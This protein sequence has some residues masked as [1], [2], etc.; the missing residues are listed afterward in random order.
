MVAQDWKQNASTADIACVFY[1]GSSPFK[2][3]QRLRVPKDHFDAATVALDRRSNHEAEFSL[4]VFY[5]LNYNETAPCKLVKLPRAKAEQENKVATK[6]IETIDW[7]KNC[8]I[9]DK[10]Q[11]LLILQYLVL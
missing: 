5:T 7:Y 3:L 1:S 6:T 8:F 11:V 9:T 4:A 2:E 10:N